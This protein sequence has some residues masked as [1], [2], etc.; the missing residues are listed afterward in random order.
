MSKSYIASALR[1]LIY[2]RAKHCCEYCF[3]PEVAALVSHEVDHIIAEKHGG[4]TQA[5]NLALSCAL[6]NKHKGSD[7]ASIDPQT[8]NIAPLY[9]PRQDNW[10]DHFS[11]NQAEFA[12]ITP[13]GRV[14]VKLLQ[15]NR[16]DRLEE[17][18]LLIK[19]GMFNLPT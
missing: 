6:C 5:D 18:K 10:S 13:I 8:G 2:E 12:G 9:N 14:T 19:A 15:L 17:R 16:Q 11:V 3:F 7:L 4:L 1:K